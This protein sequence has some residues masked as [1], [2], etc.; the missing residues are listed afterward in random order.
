MTDQSTLFETKQKDMT[1]TGSLIPK[2]LPLCSFPSSRFLKP[3]RKHFKIKLKCHILKVSVA[4]VI[5]F[6]HCYVKHDLCLAHLVTCFWEVF[7]SCFILF[8]CL[9]HQYHLITIF[10]QTNTSVNC[11]THIVM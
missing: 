8:S 6:L 4:F 5:R 7:I 11:N 10:K 1:A 3:R 2:K 9:S